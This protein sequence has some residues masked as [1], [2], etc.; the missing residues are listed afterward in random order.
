M[1]DLP[2]A[3]SLKVKSNLS[4]FIDLTTKNIIKTISGKIISNSRNGFCSVEVSIPTYFNYTNINEITNSE[5]QMIIYNKII[6]FL[7]D[8]KYS[9]KIN[10][11]KDQT[12]LIISWGTKKEYNFEALK[13]KLDSVRIN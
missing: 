2:L 3:S 8:R 7:E 4:N 9:V 10:I 13:S 12:S 5:L 1:N 6:L 11:K